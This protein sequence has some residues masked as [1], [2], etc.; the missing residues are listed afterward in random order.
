MIHQSE[1][2]ADNKKVEPKQPKVKAMT[3][4]EFNAKKA[5]NA[6][7]DQLVKNV[8]QG[9]PVEKATAKVAK[10]TTTSAGVVSSKTLTVPKSTS[11]MQVFRDNK[12]NISDVNAMSKVNNVVSNLKVG[13]RITVRLDKNNRVVE[14]NIGSG[15][16][17]TRQADGSYSFK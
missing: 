14:M 16:K 12:L 2:K 3:A 10:P 15:G 9:K 6:Q 17:F 5:K 7:L 4:D 1:N 13:E 8:E 11:L